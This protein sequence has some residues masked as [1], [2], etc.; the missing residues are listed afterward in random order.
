MNKINVLIVSLF[1]YKY[2]KLFIYSLKTKK[3]TI[4]FINSTVNGLKKW[5]PKKNKGE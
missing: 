3:K 2:H 4:F 5:K 1:I